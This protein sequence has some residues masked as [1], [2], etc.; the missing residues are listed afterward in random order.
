MERLDSGRR[1]GNFPIPT[2]TN[3]SS[4]ATT[5]SAFEEAIQATASDATPWYVVPADNKWFTR[6]V[7][8]AAIVE[9]AE[10]LNLAYPE[11]SAEKKKEL[12]AA[13]AGARRRDL[14]TPVGWQPPSISWPLSLDTNKCRRNRR[15]DTGCSEEGV[16]LGSKAADTATC[17]P[18]PVQSDF[19]CRRN[20]ASRS[21]QPTCQ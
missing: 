15:H 14:T 9:A 5:C 17:D 13:R 16:G 2:C 7:V 18:R 6:L 1:T 3:A 19:A 20:D 21:L 8:V 12:A 10:E 11:V 4:G